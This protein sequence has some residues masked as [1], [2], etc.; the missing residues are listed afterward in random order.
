MKKLIEKGSLILISLLLVFSFLEG[1]KKKKK[2]VNKYIFA[3]GNRL[4]VFD[5]ETKNVQ[6]KE[7]KKRITR[8]IYFPNMKKII[9][10]ADRRS[11]VYSININDLSSSYQVNLSQFNQYNKR[12]NIANDLTKYKNKE[13]TVLI[14]YEEWDIDWNNGLTDNGIIPQKYRRV[15]KWDISKNTFTPISYWDKLKDDPYEAREISL[16]RV[17]EYINDNRI[18]G[19]KNW[20]NK[21]ENK[22]T[23]NKRDRRDFRVVKR[24]YKNSKKFLR[25]LKKE[26]INVGNYNQSSELQVRPTGGRYMV[27]RN[28]KLYLVHMK[29]KKVYTLWDD[30]WKKL[31]YFIIE[32]NEDDVELDKE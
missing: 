27:V 3:G 26:K 6:Q 2:N 21:N 18:K 22:K 15:I 9:V 5:G 28:D 8:I 30:P 12:Y 4:V 13:N 19:W 20:I 10:N 31:R 23:G 25:L 17:E 7:F 1:A 16:Y 32:K 14:S 29:T 11:R 24:L